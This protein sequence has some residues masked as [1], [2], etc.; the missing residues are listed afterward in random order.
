MQLDRIHTSMRSRGILA[1][2][3]N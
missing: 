3:R 1:T 2:L